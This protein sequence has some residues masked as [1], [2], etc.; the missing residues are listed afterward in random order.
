MNFQNIAFGIDKH[1]GFRPIKLVSGVDRYGFSDILVEQLG[2]TF[3]PRSFANWLHGWIFWKSPLPV[4]LMFDAK[5]K[6]WMHFIVSN[7]DQSEMLHAEGFKHVWVGGLPFAYTLHSGLKRHPDSLLA[8][9]PHSSEIEKL[10][11]P[12]LDYLDYLE[13]IK[14]NYSSVWVSIFFLDKCP[15]IIHQIKRR[16]LMFIEGARP[17]D[18]NSLRRMRA[19]FDSF[20]CVTSNTMGSHIIYSIFSGC[21]T[22][23]GGPLYEY[24]ETYFLGTD[25]QNKHS[26]KYIEDSLYYLSSGYL[27]ENFK[28]LFTSTPKVGFVSKEYAEKAIGFHNKLQRNEIMEALQWGWKNQLRGYSMGGFRR[29]RRLMGYS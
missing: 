23:I 24:D 25:G 6:E 4:D 9:P 22:S 21:K 2:L 1:F 12:Y 19:I 10:N 20:D 3:R 17:D 15:E 13:S 5:Q 28:F 18:A 29:V 8:M 26:K 11:R 27:L 7:S 16:G 14:E